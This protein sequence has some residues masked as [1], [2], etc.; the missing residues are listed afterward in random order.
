MSHPIKF[1]FVLDRGKTRVELQWACAGWKRLELPT[2]FTVNFPRKRQIQNDFK[3]QKIIQRQNRPKKPEPFHAWGPAP[4]DKIFEPGDSE[5]K[6]LSG[7][8]FT[9]QMHPKIKK[10][11]PKTPPILRSGHGSG[12]S[13][14][15]SRMITKESI[16]E[17]RLLRRRPRKAKLAW[18]PPGNEA[19]D[20]APDKASFEMSLNRTQGEKTRREKLMN[21]VQKIIVK[22]DEEDRQ[23]HSGKFK[24]R[25]KEFG[26]CFVILP[27]GGHLLVG[28]FADEDYS[29]RLAYNFLEEIEMLLV[30]HEK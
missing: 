28:V 12:I 30:S 21:M 19:D 29:E 7:G 17:N 20:S 10:P 22:I 6:T 27:R 14:Q 18:T 4:L 5:K 24:F 8:K 13:F 16:I 1:C 9:I 2:T 11:R 26:N 23:S 3:S 25:N 15:S